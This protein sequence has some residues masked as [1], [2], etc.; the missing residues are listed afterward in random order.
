MRV[1]RSLR[2][3]PLAAVLL[4][5]GVS[6]YG[7]DADADKAATLLT[8]GLQQDQA[9]DYSGAKATLLQVDRNG[10]SDAQRAQLDAKLRGLDTAIKGQQE[11]R[12]ASL[13]GAK[14]L[15]AG[16]L[17]EA[18]RQYRTAADSTYLPQAARQVA[19]SELG[20]IEARMAVLAAAG[21]EK[22]AV[23]AAAPRSSEPVV[24]AQADVKP[25]PAP[26]AVRPAAPVSEEF[27]S[28]MALGK[29]AMAER[30]GAEAEAYFIKALRSEPNNPQAL[31]ALDQARRLQETSSGEQITG[32]LQ[33]ERDVARK[34]AVVD[35][36]KALDR[37]MATLAAANAENDFDKAADD[38]RIALNTLGENKGFFDSAAEY[39]AWERKINDKLRYI[40]RCKTDWSA[41]QASL[42]VRKAQRED[43]ERLRR[44]EQARRDRLSDLTR[45][46]KALLA[47]NAYEGAV[48]VLT[49][50]EHLDPQGRWAAYE[51]KKAKLELELQNQKRVQQSTNDE[52]AH[53]LRDIRESEIPWYMEIVYPNDWR[54]K[55]IRRR[56][57]QNKGGSEDAKT[58]ATKEKLK[59]PI[60][61][62]EFE[63][64]E[65]GLVIDY[66]R[67]TT[68]LS[69]YV[70]W[71]LLEGIEVTSR[72][73]V[74]IK[75]KNVSGAEAL[76]LLLSDLGAGEKRPVYKVNKAGIV[77]IS[78][79]AALRDTKLETRTYDIRDRLM[80]VP[81]FIGPRI[82]ISKLGQNQQSNTNSGLFGS[83][84]SG[85][86]GGGGGGLG[87]D[88]STGENP[89]EQRLTPQ[90]IK[91]A[92]V[93]DIMDNTGRG[94]WKE[95]T[96]D[97]G[98]ADKP[99]F[100]GGKLIVTQTP[101]VLD[102][103]EA[104][105]AELR[106]ALSVQV[107]VESRWLTVSNGWLERIGVDI[108]FTFGPDVHPFGK[109]IVFNNNQIPQ[110]SAGWITNMTSGKTGG[111]ADNMP[112]AIT[113]Q[114]Q[115]LDDVQVDFLIQATQASKDSHVLSAPRIMLMDG[116]RSYITIGKQQAYVS[117]F[118][119]QVAE[120]GVGGVGVAA[121]TPEVS[122]IPT[123]VVLDVEATV[124]ADRRYV[125]M[126]VRP[127]TSELLNME[128]VDFGNIG[129]FIMLP[130][131]QLQ[132]L[133]SSVTVPDGGTVLLGGLKLANEAE[134][135]IGVPVLSKIPVV[136]RLFE[137]RGK[138]RDAETLLI[139]V[140]P[141]IIIHR[142]IED[143]RFPAPLESAASNRR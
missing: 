104:L 88:T 54:E 36:E 97:T 125:T 48:G 23:V 61:K 22:R 93:K 38:A 123:G 120:G 12:E 114:G 77:I 59:V 65:L 50:I 90:Q 3:M 29:A 24:V 72:T 106:E 69:I 9:M 67:D 89:V 82:D 95:K 40:Q 16:N 131:L 26:K 70:N 142:E 30:K 39:A 75:L 103:I 108:D 15:E 78:T 49:E 81:N 119:T 96:P 46:A 134:R 37:S 51:L 33:T 111:I 4:M 140:S 5:S 62:L 2:I 128:R 64:Q 45:Q 13:S 112:T 27:Q 11:A 86:G 63:N 94:T 7:Q 80:L 130:T 101:E 141:K 87:G 42:S 32:K 8:K 129:G 135:E 133:Q 68:D 20:R 73:S 126:T 113:M 117:A 109:K 138:V 99:T 18:R 71:K 52:T 132:D 44:E 124:S 98:V 19:Q 91:D 53:S 122:W 83:T 47:E 136:N 102:Q 66:I 6:A 28:Y 121:A 34:A 107:L 92:L 84:S 58:Q 31:L 10:L 110:N 115:F 118:S 143:L 35:M 56:M 139:L 79:E 14:A 116:Q 76:D 100:Q 137:N 74:N 25:A 57:Y 21:A 105:L 43:I 55:T 85:G 17:A 1:L 41:S 127:Q 60:G